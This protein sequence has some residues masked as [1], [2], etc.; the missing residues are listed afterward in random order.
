MAGGSLI[1]GLILAGCASI[2]FDVPKQASYKLTDTADTILGQR[3]ARLCATQKGLSGFELQRNGIEA[4][5][6]RV[7]LSEHV[8]QSIDAQYYLVSD[9]R[10]GRLFLEGLLEAADRGV[11]VRFLLDDIQTQGIEPILA[12][13]DSHPHVETRIF[14]PFASRRIRWGDEVFDFRR[15]NRRMHNKSFIVDNAFAIV[16]GRNIADEYFGAN[17][18]QNFGDAD[19][20]CVGPVVDGVASMFDDYWNSRW[21]I[22]LAE[23]T[24]PAEQTGTVLDSMRNAF[25]ANRRTLGE[26][27]YGRALNHNIEFFSKSAYIDWHWAESEV[28]H[29]PP[30]KVR[31][32]DYTLNDG[33]AGQLSRVVAK[34]KQEV[35]VISPYFV[36][37]E[38]GMNYFQHLIDRG[39]RVR[40]V[41]NSLAANNHGIV[42]SGYMGY[43][44][45]LLKMG[46]ELYEVRVN[47]PVMG[48]NR[49]YSGAALAT[50]HTKAFLID[51]DTFFLGSFNWDPRS[52]CLNTELGIVVHSESM[53]KSI[54][55]AMSVEIPDGAYRLRLDAKDQIEWI[56]ESGPSPVRYASEPDVSWWRLFKAQVGRLLP[57]RDQL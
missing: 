57:I 24:E 56:D 29:D 15:I 49:G 21:A 22:P 38:S 10:V 52:V 48:V 14:N 37:L 19:L 45:R 51:R 7:V 1:V 20:L 55:E 36:P 9:D 18:T 16:G 30:S 8:E 4:L 47:A 12:A 39:L 25:A 28:V 26:T 32:R 54:A 50:L 11:R 13:L 17:E 43:R 6:A 40:I 23:L 46:V 27:T 2:N 33:I 44:K 34:A 53:S 5:A 31:A 42:H 41:T 3:A 35:V